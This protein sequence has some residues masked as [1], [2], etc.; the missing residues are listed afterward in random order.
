MS[1]YYEKFFNAYADIEILKKFFQR[2]IKVKSFD[3]LDNALKPGKG[4]LFVTGHYG[5][6]EYIPIFLGMHCYPVSVVAKFA[7]KHLK[8]STYLKTK[9]LGIKLIDAAEEG[10]VLPLIIRELKENRI[11]FIE[12]DEIEEWKPSPHERIY[13]LRKLIGV[14]KTINLIQRRTDAEVVFGL[15]H[16]CSMRDYK[17]IMKTY[18]EMSGVQGKS[19]CSIGE[20]ILKSFEQF[21]YSYPEEWYQWKNYADIKTLSE[22]GINAEKSRPPSLLKPAFGDI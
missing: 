20:T 13:F 6:V 21:V 15:L 22:P 8:E 9:D 3:A 10:K 5:G 4:V 11:V 14:D 1:H 2:S 16:R 19:V 17:L 7:T 12:C 18:Y